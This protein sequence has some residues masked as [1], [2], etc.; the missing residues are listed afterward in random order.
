MIELMD[1]DSESG[2]APYGWEEN[3]DPMSVLDFGQNFKKNKNNV[4][5]K[6]RVA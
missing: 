3:S 5:I 6:M 1:A 4:N 2:T